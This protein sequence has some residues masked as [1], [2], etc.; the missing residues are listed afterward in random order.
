MVR[1]GF[2]LA[3]AGQQRPN[4]QDRSG[5]ER[6]LRD[7]RCYRCFP[8]ERW[9]DWLHIQVKAVCDLLSG[10]VWDFPAILLLL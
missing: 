5:H 4:E 10:A 2:S 3:D 8:A 9:Y 7:L 1:E 6:S